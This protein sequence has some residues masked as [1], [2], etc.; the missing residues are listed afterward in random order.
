MRKLLLTVKKF[1]KNLFAD[2]DQKENTKENFLSF[3]TDGILARTIISSSAQYS[4]VED[5]VYSSNRKNKPKLAERI[6]LS[7]KEIYKVCIWQ[8]Y[9]GDKHFKALI[10]KSPKVVGVYKDTLEESA[11]EAEILLLTSGG[12]NFSVNNLLEVLDMSNK[13]VVIVST[14]KEETLKNRI[15]YRV[16]HCINTYKIYTQEAFD[17]FIDTIIE[18]AAKPDV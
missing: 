15:M 9:G 10:E 1:I 12:D 7:Q 17:K 5:I 3:K 2:T 16:D 14:F 13:Y 18:L 11:A 8:L 4:D 6:P